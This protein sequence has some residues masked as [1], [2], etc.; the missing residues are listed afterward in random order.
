MR[1]ILLLLVILTGLFG[2]S[3]QAGGG[4]WPADAADLT[5]NT[6]SS[7]SAESTSAEVFASEEEDDDDE[8]D[9]QVL[10][11][12]TSATHSPPSPTA[13]SKAAVVPTAPS[14]STWPWMVF[15]LTG[16]STV[17]GRR[18]RDL[19]TYLRLNL[20]ARLDADYNDVSINRI[21]VTAHAVVANLSVEPT[22]LN[23]DGMGAVG[24]E[25]LAHGNVTLLELSG[26]EFQVER[27]IRCD[28][29]SVDKR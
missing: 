21:V 6:N 11:V 22:Y 1:S 20:A 25:S 16:N 19:G 29:Q 27:I 10:L 9:G 23:R 15:V 24:I 28:D 2:A 3:H 7:S 8:G 17:A 13:E 26:H 14:S 12:M 5:N 18:Q 4:E